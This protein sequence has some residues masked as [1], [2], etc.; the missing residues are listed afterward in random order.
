VIDQHRGPVATLVRL[1]LFACHHAGR[2]E[3]GGA[4]WSARR[5]GR[6]MR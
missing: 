6:G 5:Q 1:S 4:A 2:P 3:P